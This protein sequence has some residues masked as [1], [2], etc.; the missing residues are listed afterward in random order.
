M[1]F[2][3][4]LNGRDQ[5]RPRDYQR[6]FEHAAAR[7]GSG[8]GGARAKAKHLAVGAVDYV[9][10]LSENGDL[11]PDTGRIRQGDCLTR[12]WRT[13]K[14]ATDFAPRAGQAEKAVLQALTFSL[15]LEDKEIG[16]IHDRSHGLTERGRENPEC[17]RC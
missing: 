12:N 5:T 15:L 8:G 3:D 14:D 13:P 17:S 7:I 6:A 16:G 9:C 2:Y 4:S 1:Q 10:L 11:F